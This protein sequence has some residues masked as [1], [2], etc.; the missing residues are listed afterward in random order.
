MVS[1][2]MHLRADRPRPAGE[3]PTGT[4]PTGPGRT[5]QRLTRTAGSHAGHRPSSNSTPIVQFLSVIPSADAT[6]AD[7][8][9]DIDPESSE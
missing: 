3:R 9:L 1:T 7:P 6:D 8:T 2:T 4:R 5:G